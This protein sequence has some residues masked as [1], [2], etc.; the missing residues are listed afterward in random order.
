MRLKLITYSIILALATSCSPYED[1]NNEHKYN[2]LVEKELLSGMRNDTIILGYRF[3]MTEN[4]IEYHTNKL[5]KNK[6]VRKESGDL[7][8]DLNI[9]EKN[10]PFSYR[11]GTYENK[12]NFFRAVSEDVKASELNTLLIEKHGAHQFTEQ[13]DGVL[14]M[15]TYHWIKGNQE[16]TSTQITGGYSETVLIFRDKSNQKPIDL[17]SFNNST[18]RIENS[19]WDGSVSQV[20]DYLSQNLKDPE[21]YEGLDWS[22]VQ[23]V[24]ENYRVR[25]KYRAKN[26]YGGYMLENQVFTINKDGTIIKV[27]DF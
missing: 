10:I 9:E 24:G 25:H 14:K 20:K 1:S 3:G 16:I 27:Q 22:P 12:L 7:I 4:Q 8:F 11:T 15:T 21:S 6:K 18:V 17:S 5:I 13:E 26:S 19:S 23:K 2:T